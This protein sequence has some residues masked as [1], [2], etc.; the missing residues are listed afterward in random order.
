MKYH[1]YV[2][3]DSGSMGLNRLV[4]NTQGYM[5]TVYYRRANGMYVEVPTLLELT[6]E[7]IERISK[8]SPESPGAAH[9]AEALDICWSVYE[10]LQSVADD[11]CVERATG[12]LSL[13]SLGDNFTIGDDG[14]AELID[15]SA[16]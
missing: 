8:L 11:G 16:V 12:E 2:E 1:E 6:L 14:L 9:I 5:K 7:H 3:F 13:S 4:S 10:S 15:W